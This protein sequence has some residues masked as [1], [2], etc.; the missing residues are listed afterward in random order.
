MVMLQ[1]TATA[2]VNHSDYLLPRLSNSLDFFFL[3]TLSAGM[4]L[5]SI[6]RHPLTY[7]IKWISVA[8]ASS[9][10]CIWC[11]SELGRPKI[12]LFLFRRW[13]YYEDSSITNVLT[14]LAPPPP[15]V[16]SEELDTSI[17]DAS[18]L[19]LQMYWSH[20]LSTSP[21]EILVQSLTNN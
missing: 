21:S 10:W 14:A 4:C 11:M 13:K 16:G 20:I 12:T 17:F 15:C 1:Y 9:L 2:V 5:G 19:C 8:S 18:Q 7:Q 3:S 6:N